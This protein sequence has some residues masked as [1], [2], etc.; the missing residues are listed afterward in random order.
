[1]ETTSRLILPR[2]EALR[3]LRRPV[4]PAAPIVKWAGGKTR[5]MDELMA[6]RPTEFRRY[7]EPFVGGAAFF[8]RMQPQ[9]AVLSD[10]NTDLMNVYRAVTGGDHDDWDEFRAAMVEEGRLVARLRPRSVTGQI[11]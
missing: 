2:K 1:M 10:V 7:Y 5:I 9:H 3:Q 6:R 4:A 11:R 8:F